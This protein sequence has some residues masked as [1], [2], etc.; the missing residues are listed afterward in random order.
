MCSGNKYL[1]TIEYNNK[2]VSFNFHDNYMNKSDKEEFIYCLI[3]DSSCYESTINYDDFCSCLGYEPYE[4]KSYYPYSGY[5]KVARAAYNGCKKQY[6]RLHKLFTV[7]EIEK[8]Q[9][10]FENF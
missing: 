10:I 1:V 7:D 6:E 4:E 9:V 2:K 5:N 8:L 3:S